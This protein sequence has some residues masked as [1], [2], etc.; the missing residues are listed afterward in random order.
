MVAVNWQNHL[1]VFF[2]TVPS[3]VSCLVEVTLVAPMP[4][5]PKSTKVKTLWTN[6]SWRLIRSSSQT[7]HG[8][9]VNVLA[10]RHIPR[11]AAV[12]PMSFLRGPTATA[13]ALKQSG[14]DPMEYANR[15]HVLG[16]YHSQDIHKWTRED[17]REYTCLWHPQYVCSCGNVGSVTREG[18]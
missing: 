17:A 16:K 14:K 12:C 1:G 2:P 9:S 15:M 4:T 13:T 18:G 5:I 6:H 3:A 10:S 8:L 11:N 7:W